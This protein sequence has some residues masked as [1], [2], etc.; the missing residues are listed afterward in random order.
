M[1]SSQCKDNA[2]EQ[3]NGRCTECNME[4]K[5]GDFCDK[6]MSN[7]PKGWMF[8]SSDRNGKCIGGCKGEYW[9]QGC[10]QTCPK[11]CV[12]SIIGKS[13]DNDTGV[14]NSCPEGFYGDSCESKCPIYCEKSLMY[15][16]CT[17]QGKCNYCKKGFE[18]NC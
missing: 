17:R 18:F 5:Y 3:P 1:C 11:N 15:S 7:C 4:E 13:C 16:L 14:C 9:G 2:C 10:K 6:L 8:S 12:K